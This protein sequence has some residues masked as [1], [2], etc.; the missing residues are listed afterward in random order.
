MSV[1]PARAARLTGTKE[2]RLKAGRRR[3]SNWAGRPGAARRYRLEI[4]SSYPASAAPGRALPGKAGRGRLRHAHPLPLTHAHMHARTHALPW[5]RGRSAH[6][7]GSACSR[8]RRRV[9][10]FRRAGSAAMLSLPR[11]LGV[12][13]PAALR[14]RGSRILGG[15]AAR[16]K[17]WV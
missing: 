16:V 12:G 3:H 15:K 6:R 4:I 7:Q 13:M 14:C 9:R 5:A 1:E 11:L 8:R 2:R 10:D 17:S